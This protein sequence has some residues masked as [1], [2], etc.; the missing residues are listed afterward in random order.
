[1]SFYVAATRS[2]GPDLEW[3]F[4]PQMTQSGNSPT[5]VWKWLEFLILD[6]VNLT[7]KINITVRDILQA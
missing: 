7:T 5:G 2:Y 1:M 4:P 3:A 6:I